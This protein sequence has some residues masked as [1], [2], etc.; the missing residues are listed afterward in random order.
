M[1]HHL[2]C[3]SRHFQA[4]KIYVATI[5]SHAHIQCTH[6]CNNKSL[7]QPGLQSTEASARPGLAVLLPLHSCRH[8]HVLVDSPMRLYMCL[9]AHKHDQ[10]R[11]RPMNKSKGTTM[12]PWHF[13]MDRLS[14]RDQ[15]KDSQTDQPSELL[16]EG[17][18]EVLLLC[19]LIDFR[20]Y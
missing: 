18:N 12:R 16:I 1:P 5:T 3:C 8:I 6:A 19:K 15:W 2:P 14:C 11:H 4:D 10:S 7:S 9:Y 13:Q 20:R 17:C